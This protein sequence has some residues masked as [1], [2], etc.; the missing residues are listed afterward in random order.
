MSCSACPKDPLLVNRLRPSLPTPDNNPHIPPPDYHTLINKCK[1]YGV[2]DLL[3]K[4]EIDKLYSEKFPILEDYDIVFLIDDSG[5]MNTPLKQGP[6]E[7]RWD[8]LKS[9]I[10]IVIE[11]ANI[12]DDDGI[13]LYFLNRDPVYC[14]NSYRNIDDILRDKPYGQ[15]PLTESCCQI[16]SHFDQSEKPVLLVIATDG[17]PTDSH[18]HL[19]IDNFTSCIK[20]RNADKIFISFLACSD[21]E[22]D[23][24]YLNKLDK[25]EKN[26]DT[27]D[28]YL[29]EKKEVI[30]AQGKNFSYSLGDHTARLLLGPL[31]PQL[32]SLD[33]TRLKIKKKCTI[34]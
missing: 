21:S 32:D 10:K 13:D 24:A 29:S 7:T 25:K 2:E 33:E 34:L 23:I 1:G 9:V 6:H 22:N 5:S 16:F 4:Y 11:I 3:R 31:C 20:N 8:E 14:V 12:F 30:A 27:L 19:D 18:G 28:D 15:T 26:I 17:V